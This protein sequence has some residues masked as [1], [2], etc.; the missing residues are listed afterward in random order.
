MS[1]FTTIE[2][3]IRNIPALE[4]ACAE[5]GDTLARNTR[6]RGWMNQTT[7]GDYVIQLPGQHDVAL[8]RQPNGSYQIVADF[9]DTTIARVLGKSCQKLVQTYAVHRTMAQLQK[10]G[11]IGRREQRADGFIAIH[12]RV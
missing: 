8:K 3:E 9:Y 6:A 7:E 10:K 1:H 5:L 11:R 12:V 2:T 4:T